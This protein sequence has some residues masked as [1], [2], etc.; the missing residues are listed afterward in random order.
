MAKVPCVLYTSTSSFNGLMTTFTG[1]TVRNEVIR[2]RVWQPYICDP[3]RI[4]LSIDDVFIDT[5]GDLS[6][7]Q[8]CNWV[9]EQVR[10]LGYF[11]IEISR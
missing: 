4:T 10:S 8:G 11:V 6:F 3:A 2:A 5:Q 7:T 1:R 9:I